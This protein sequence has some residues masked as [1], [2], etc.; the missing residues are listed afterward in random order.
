MH[1]MEFRL[2]VIHVVSIHIRMYAAFSHAEGSLAALL[3]TIEQTISLIDKT[4]DA[5]ARQTSNDY[6]CSHDDVT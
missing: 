1:A 5:G 2:E 4:V 3:A 6:N